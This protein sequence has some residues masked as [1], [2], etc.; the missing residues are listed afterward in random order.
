MLWKSSYVCGF[1]KG[2]SENFFFVWKVFNVSNEIEDEGGLLLKDQW[3]LF[4]G[5]N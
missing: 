3:N 5:V 1:K 4:L 2:T